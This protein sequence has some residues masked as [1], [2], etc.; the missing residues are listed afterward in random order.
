MWTISSLDLVAA[1]W[2]ANDSRATLL[3]APMP[4]VRATETGRLL[5]LVGSGFG[6]SGGF[7]V[8][9]DRIHLLAHSFAL[10]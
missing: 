1:P 9:R 7:L 8:G 3:P 10:D 5:V 2:R 6:G 4:P